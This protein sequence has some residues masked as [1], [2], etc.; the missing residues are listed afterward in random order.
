MVELEEREVGK[1]AVDKID[2]IQHALK[3]AAAMAPDPRE[4]AYNGKCYE[5]D[6]IIPERCA[7]GHPIRQVFV[8]DR[9]RDGATLN[10]GCVCIDSTVPHIIASGNQGLAEA[11]QKA[12]ADLEAQIKARAKEKRD[13][14]ASV[15]VQGL[16]EEYETLRQWVRDLKQDMAQN[17]EYVPGSIY[18][19]IKGL[20][21]AAST[22]GRTA[23]SIRTRYESVWLEL[24]YLHVRG[25]YTYGNY[26]NREYLKYLPKP[27][28]PKDEKLRKRI[29]KTLQS[30]IDFYQRYPTDTTYQANFVTCSAQLVL[31]LGN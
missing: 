14:E 19:G 27:P 16:A 18:G 28:I 20:P 26:S 12:K 8:I 1:E 23:A 25:Y 29:E 4:W 21:K 24:S 17:K 5:A 7:C 30:K 9:E 22:P 11:L 13:A 6:G 2:N 31:L 15:E 10:I 3:I